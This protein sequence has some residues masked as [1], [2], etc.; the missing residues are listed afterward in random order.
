MGCLTIVLFV[1]VTSLIVCY[2]IRRKYTYW[3]RRG[4]P[5]VPCKFPFGNMGGIDGI[6]HSHSPH[7][8]KG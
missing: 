2:L 5:Y 7:S 8:I 4:V 1:A 6:I 3:Q